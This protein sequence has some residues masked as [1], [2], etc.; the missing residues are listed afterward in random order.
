MNPLGLP[1]LD[2]STI[3]LSRPPPGQETNFINPPSLSWVGRLAIYLTLPLAVV[4]VTLRTYV[5]L[6]TRQV[7]PD[8]CK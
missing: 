7:G 8:D 5:R 4:A 1:G 2:L 6:R 3:P